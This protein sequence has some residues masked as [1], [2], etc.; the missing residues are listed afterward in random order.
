MAEPTA[1]ALFNRYDRALGAALRTRLNARPS[2]ARTLD[3]AAQAMSPAFRVLVAIM[4]LW[5]PTRM[6]GVQ[7]LIAAVI[8]ALLAKRLRD[9]IARPRPGERSEGSMPSRHAAAAVA[10]ASV[11]ADRHRGVGL[12]LATATAVGLMG[13]IS[14]G[15]HDPADLVA[16]ALIGRG[17]AGLVVRV[18]APSA[19]RYRHRANGSPPAA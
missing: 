16:G 4:I 5:R 6:R 10:I 12:P 18:G 9:D 14:T 8:A 19:A 1:D 7:A 2:V 11:L 13:R 3:G 15:D 17:V